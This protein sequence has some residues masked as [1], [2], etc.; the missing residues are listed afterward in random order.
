M[1]KKVGQFFLEKTKFQNLG[2]SDQMR[3]VRSPNLE[4]E[5]NRSQKQFDLPK[6]DSIEVNHLNVKTA[7][8]KRQSVRHYRK[9]PLSLEE[10]SVLLWCTQGV[11]EVY[12]GSATLRTVPS[13]GARH[14]F[15]T[16]LLINQVK[17]LQPGL[18]RFLAIDH[19][20]VEVDLNP[21]LADHLT[22][23]CL[24]QNFVKESA[25]TSI[26]A[27]VPS[28]MIW[29]YGERGYRYLFLDA[30]HVCQNLYLIAEAMDCGVCA[31]GAFSDDDINHIL[32][33]NETDQFVIYLATIGKK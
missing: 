26:W 2:T 3:G 8:E 14:A 19:K 5:F 15:E 17:G 11:K 27:A 20:L 12:S 21:R 4:L 33:F 30:G 18:Y 31:I 10:L 1:E 32:N 24:G 28:R 7:I 29:R 6:P 25:V 22:A 13:A 16:Y 9:I 23:A